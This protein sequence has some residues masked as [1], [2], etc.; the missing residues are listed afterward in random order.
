MGVDLSLLNIKF[1]MVA[2]ALHIIL[3]PILTGRWEQEEI[4]WDESLKKVNVQLAKVKE[5]GRASKDIQ[6][7]VE[8]L[9]AQEKKLQEKLNVVRQI[10][11]IKKNPL[12]IMLFLTKNMPPDVWLNTLSLEN[13]ALVLE[14][15]SSSYRSI[16]IFIENLQGSIFFGNS[17]KLEDSRTVNLEKSKNREEMFKIS[18]TIM[19]YE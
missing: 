12:G 17:I 16:G 3:V 10:I 8:A 18:G 2:L 6:E 7:K 4:D 9:N 14:G 13:D 19:R 11:K 1:I 15:S 5:E